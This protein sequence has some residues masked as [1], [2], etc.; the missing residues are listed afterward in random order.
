M[1]DVSTKGKG[2]LPD[3][4]DLRNYRLDMVFEA[5]ELPTEYD[6][7]DKI[8]WTKDQ[9]SSGSCGGQA[10]SYYMEVLSF[11]RDGV[12]TKL[13]ARDL[14]APVH[15]TS[16]GSRASDLLNQLSNNGIALEED[17]PSYENGNPPSEAF[18]E[19]MTVR[20]QSLQA[21][22]MQYWIDN[23]YL[24]FDSRSIDQVKQAIFKGNGAV[25]AVWG[26]NTCW[27]TPNGEIMVPGPGAA[28]WGHFIYLTGW[29][30]RNGQLYFKFKN[31]WGNEWGDNGFGY[32]PAKYLTAGF[33][34]SEWTVVELPKDKY[35]GMI[36]VITLLKNLIDLIRQKLTI[37]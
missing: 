12:Y 5:T 13:S 16:G 24:T 26:N 19:R 35:S 17:V 15:V 14:Y 31:S 29:Q 30:I 28:T 32:L 36:K 37:K 10:F 11:I 6:I 22:A 2:A 34:Q 8:Q 7:S 25:M 23:K 9:G 21:K 20:N 33:G 3:K 18:M 27:T 4:V 1:I